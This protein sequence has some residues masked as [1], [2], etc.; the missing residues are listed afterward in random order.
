MTSIRPYILI[1]NDD[2]IEAPG[3]QA[4]ADALDPYYDLVIVAPHRER[5]GA[6]HAISVLRDLKLEKFHRKETHWGWSFQGKPADCVKVGALVI[7]KDRP[8][9]LVVSG[10]NR[11]QNLGINVLY[12]GT[13]A[14]AREGV[15]LGIPSI[16]F[17]QTYRDLGNV[18]FESGGKVA[19]EIV[20]RVLAQGL[21]KGIFLNVNIPDLPYGEIAGF[22]ITRQGNS[23]FR[24]KFEHVEGH[25]EAGGLFR[26]V[27]DRFYK[28]TSEQIDLDDLAI[29]RKKVSIT[30]LHIDATA[31]EYLTSL[32]TIANGTLSEAK[33]SPEEG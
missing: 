23:G 10:I 30:P 21:P 3:L 16:A 32:Q 28:S 25:P 26:N 5:S 17:S 15:V 2:G 31:H 33:K 11:G 8:V 22:E 20:R 19:L 4:L 1:T 14:G 7:A 27:G 24:D 18:Q 9:D 6:G 12:S 29:K 13:V